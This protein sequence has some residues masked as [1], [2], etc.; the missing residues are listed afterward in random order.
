MLAVD[1]GSA[2]IVK[3]LLE[4]GADPNIRNE[5]TAPQIMA[6]TTFWHYDF[7]VMLSTLNIFGD[8]IFGW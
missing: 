4:A 1:D 8:R 6:H 2:D 7:K 3:I 5:V